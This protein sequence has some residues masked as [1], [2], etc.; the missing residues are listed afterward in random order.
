M[1]LRYFGCGMTRSERETWWDVAESCPW[2]TFF[3]TPL[4]ADLATVRGYEPNPVRATVDGADIVF[5]AVKE[6]ELV[7][8]FGVSK[9]LTVLKSMFAG[10][11]GGWIAPDSAHLPDAEAYETVERAADVV[12]LAGNPITPDSDSDHAPDWSESEDFTQIL[13]LSV[14]YDEIEQSFSDGRRWGVEAARDKGVTVS[15]ADAKSD[16]EAYFGAYEASLE[17]WDEPSSVYSW[18][19]FERLFEMSEEYTDNVKLW[20]AEVDGEVASGAVVLYWNDHA[21]YWHGASHAE[22]FDYQPNDLLQAEI[23][24]DATRRNFRWYDFNPSGGHE[25]VVNF[26]SAFGP[27]RRTIRRWEYRDPTVQMAKFVLDK[28]GR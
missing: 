19:F 23:I 21:D 27:E 20:L 26:K 10:T 3:H 28:L 24:E 8:K 16:W 1:Y 2:A 7:K 4:W 22:Y 5:P 18:G 13:D 17:R 25:G 14:G 12:L 6:T 11:Y 15:V 9:S